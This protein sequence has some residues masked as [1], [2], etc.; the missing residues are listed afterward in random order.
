MNKIDFLQ[1]C[2]VAHLS[3]PQLELNIIFNKFGI[4]KNYK[5][6]FDEILNN[7]INNECTLL[8]KSYQNSFEQL[9]FERNN[10]IDKQ[11]VNECNNLTAH[12]IDS[13]LNFGVLNT[14]VQLTYLPILTKKEEF[15]IFR[16][17]NL[18]TKFFK[19]E[20]VIKLLQCC[21][22]N[23]MTNDILLSSLNVYAQNLN[24]VKTRCFQSQCFCSRINSVL[25][26]QVNDLV[27]NCQK[28]SKN[29]EV[30]LRKISKDL[31]YV[32]NSKKKYEIYDVIY[33]SKKLKI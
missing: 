22:N 28:S 15:I 19:F 7:Y 12:T 31:I 30:L 29:I 14:F 20:I 25:Q 18:I 3:E 8:I 11:I 4:R 5:D 6:L 33:Q 9:F 26:Y 23:K 16:L 21:N 2:V 10:F 27:E 17:L 1:E 24:I 13:I 32:T